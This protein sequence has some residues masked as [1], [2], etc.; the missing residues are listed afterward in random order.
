[1]WPPQPQMH[2]TCAS[3]QQDPYLVRICY[4]VSLTGDV[5][6]VLSSDNHI[7]CLRHKQAST[8]MMISMLR[9][10]RLKNFDHQL[11]SV[12][13]NSAQLCLLLDLQLW[14]WL[15][16]VCMRWKTL[17]HWS[18]T[19][20]RSK[21]ASASSYLPANYPQSQDPNDTSHFISFLNTV[22]D[23]KLTITMSDHKLRR[24]LSIR[25]ICWRLHMPEEH[26]LPQES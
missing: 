26:T 9:R 10:W 19:R 18:S 25:S 13:L 12:Q 21:F 24:N 8:G 22:F 2:L 5:L 17:R 14:R 7:C 6:K 11:N 3:S 15:L 23:F 1:M 4:V 16:A 20:H